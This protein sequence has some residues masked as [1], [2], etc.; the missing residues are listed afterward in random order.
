[1]KASAFDPRCLDV[2]VFIAADAEL[3]GLCP[4][5]AMDRLHQQRVGHASL[6]AQVTWQAQGLTKPGTL[7]R[8][9]HW[10]TL[11]AQALV[12]LPCQRCLN[13]LDVAL[14]LD[15]RLRF[16][17]DEARA[18]ELDM[19]CDYDVLAFERQLD[20]LQLIEDE[21]LLVM[22]LVPRHEQCPLPGADSVGPVAAVP[23]LERPNPFAALQALRKG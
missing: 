12:Q 17:E 23:D 13:G 11:Q 4:I 10:L 22:P 18:A 3:A 7:G 14:R 19:Q 9:E 15:T 2:A 5:S 21:L 20:L 6:D 8:A 1:M 16:V